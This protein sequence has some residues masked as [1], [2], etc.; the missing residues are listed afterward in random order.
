MALHSSPSTGTQLDRIR[1]AHPG[2]MVVISRCE[3]C[4][5]HKG[6]KVHAKCSKIK[7][8]RYAAQG[9]K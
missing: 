4:G 9:G 1:R 6:H 2:G 3:I 8:Q 7:Q 5:I